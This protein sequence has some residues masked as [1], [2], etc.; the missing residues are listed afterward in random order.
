MSCSLPYIPLYLHHTSQ[1]LIQ[2][3]YVGDILYHRCSPEKLENPYKTVS[4]TELSH[5]IGTNNKVELS[6]LEDVL[7]STKE[8]EELQKYD[9]A[10]CT[11]EIKSLNDQQT[12]HKQFEQE[13]NGKVYKCVMELL[14]DPLPCMY[15]HCIFRVWLDGELV[16]YDNYKSTIRKLKKIKTQLK[17]ELGNMIVQRE[18]RQ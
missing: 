10:V 9:K 14:H 8:E 12:Y 6:K 16:T 5:N 11:L 18:V 17:Q 7:W 2:C 4:I 15:P 13:K 3:F 1:E